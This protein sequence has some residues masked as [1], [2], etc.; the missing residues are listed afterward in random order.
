MAACQARVNAADVAARRLLG[1]L[2]GLVNAAYR[3]FNVHHHAALDA[4][5]GRCAQP[6]QAQLA[7]GLHFASHGHDFGGAYVQAGDQVL[8][9]FRHNVSLVRPFS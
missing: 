2:D 5:A 4:L 6:Y 7:V 8:M 9:F 1:L 3:G